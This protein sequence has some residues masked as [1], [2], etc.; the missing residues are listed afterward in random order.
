[1]TPA[2]LDQHIACCARLMEAAMEKGDRDEAVAWQQAMYAAI[3]GRTPEHRQRIEAEIQA[4]I[5][6]DAAHAPSATRSH[7][8]W[9]WSFVCWA[10][11]HR[12]IS[13][14]KWVADYE[15]AP[16]KN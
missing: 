10:I 14:G 15:N 3:A 13:L 12:S 11:H 5:E 6:G 4:R 7:L 8:N 1:M 2:Q 16:C 9:L